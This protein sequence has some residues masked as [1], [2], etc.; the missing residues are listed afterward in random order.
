MNL[1]PFKMLIILLICLVI[2]FWLYL[3][4]EYR[5]GFSELIDARAF[6]ADFYNTH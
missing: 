4:A 2:G 3:Q 6:V 5:I 1:H